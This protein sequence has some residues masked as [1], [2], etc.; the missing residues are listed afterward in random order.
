MNKCEVIAIA[1]QKGGVGKTTT[2]FNLGIALSKQGKKVLLVDTD[3]QGDLTISMGFREQIDFDYTLADILNQTIND[4]NIDYNRFILTHDEEIDLIPANLDL[5]AIEMNL[6]NAMSREYVLKN[7]LKDLKNKYDYILID[8]QPSLGMLTI[9]SLAFADKV[10]I[11][12]Q[13][14]YLAAKNTSQLISIVNK[15]KHQL[16]EKLSI[17]GILITLVDKRTNLSKETEK[18]L[19]NSYGSIV[20]IY[21]SQIPSA[22][23]IAESSSQGKSIFSYDKNSKCAEAY[24]KFSMEVIKDDKKKSR[25]VNSKD[26]SRQDK[27]MSFLNLCVYPE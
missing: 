11:S 4:K 15:V 3:P 10:I 25:D 16:N 2:T 13:S 20:N 17:G 12:V 14:Q 9:N 27:R 24:Y 26:I 1:N 5:S 19:E 23:R 18:L 21:D 22:T 7:S 6:F 8:C